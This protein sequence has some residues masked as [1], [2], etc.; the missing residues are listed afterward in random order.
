M[1]ENAA[2]FMDRNPLFPGKSCFPLSPSKDSAKSINGF[3][4][5]STD[6]LAIIFG[7]I[8]TPN[9]ADRSFVTD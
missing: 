1:K 2:T 9:E 4:M 8:G 7:T 6:Q 5:A 3:P